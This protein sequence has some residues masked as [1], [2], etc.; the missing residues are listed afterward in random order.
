MNIEYE[1]SEA[2]QSITIM[3]VSESFEEWR[4]LVALV[5]EIHDRIASNHSYD[6]LCA[7]LRTDPRHRCLRIEV[8]DHR[9]EELLEMYKSQPAS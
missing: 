2:A 5:D 3:L 4:K 9:N 8:V 1:H 7:G 6:G